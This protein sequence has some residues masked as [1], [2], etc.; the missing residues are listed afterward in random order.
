[1][2]ASGILNTLFENLH[3]L[4]IGKLFSAST[5]G[6]FGKAKSLAEQPQLT[7]AAVVGRVFF[8]VFS[9]LQN[10]T[11]SLKRTARKSIISLAMIFFPLMIGFAVT[12]Q[13]FI[14]L[15]LTNKW[16]ES[17]PYFQLLCIVNLFYPLHLINLLILKAVGRSD[18]FFKIE[19]IKKALILSAILVTIQ[20]GIIPMIY[21]LITVSFVCYYLSCF[22]TKQLIDYTFYRQCMDVLPY[23]A[24]SVVMG[25]LIYLIG[26]L[27]IPNLVIKLL[28]QFS[29]GV[30]FYGLA[31]YILKLR[32]FLETTD[33]VLQRIKG[34]GYALCSIERKV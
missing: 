2:L 20:F 9:I 33:T 7:L 30:S 28:L 32:E 26:I 12:A 25:S 11:L 19:I 13:N 18:L 3:L 5:L 14:V 1:M 15:L 8:P 10:D 6:F 16:L 17:V 29:F 24:V 4:I 34:F 22:Y 23:L 31:C 21:G 27:N